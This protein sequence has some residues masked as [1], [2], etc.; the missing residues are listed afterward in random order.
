MEFEE[1]TSQLEEVTIDK[2]CRTCLSTS[3]ELAVTLFDV[4]EEEKTNF[5]DMITI[6]FGKIVN[7]E[8]FTPIFLLIA[9]FSFRCHHF[10]P[11]Q[12]DYAMSVRSSLGSPSNLDPGV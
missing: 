9:F 5:L 2:V 1:K 3:D 10:K 6:C 8:I 7:K 11:F 4:D 12:Q